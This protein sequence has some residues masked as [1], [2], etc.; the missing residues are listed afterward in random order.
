MS[1]LKRLDKKWDSL[2]SIRDWQ[3]FKDKKEEKKN[4]KKKSLEWVEEQ[5][6]KSAQIKLLN[7]KPQE[8][9]YLVD[10]LSNILYLVCYPVTLKFQFSF[11]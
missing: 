10:N 11:D 4:F 5:K 3:T 1:L 2:F 7:K 6:N 8:L 9:C